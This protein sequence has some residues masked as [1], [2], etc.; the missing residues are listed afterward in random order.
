MATQGEIDPNVRFASETIAQAI[1]EGLGMIADRIAAAEPPQRNDL[2]EHE[3]TESRYEG[4]W[5]LAHSNLMLTEA[6]IAV[7]NRLEDGD[8]M[9]ETATA[10]FEMAKALGA[11]ND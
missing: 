2:Y 8:H 6:V 11:N 3:P 7:Q 4:A 1:R 10:L 9:K 5:N